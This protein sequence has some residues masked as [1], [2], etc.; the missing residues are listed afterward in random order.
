MEATEPKPLRLHSSHNK[1]LTAVDTVS[2]QGNIVNNQH[3]IVH[4]TNTILKNIF[5]NKIIRDK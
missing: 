4:F 1:Y 2:G 3:S 5:I